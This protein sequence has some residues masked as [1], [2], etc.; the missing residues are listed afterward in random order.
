M[1]SIEGEDVTELTFDPATTLLS[2]V[3]FALG[4]YRLCAHH[5]ATWM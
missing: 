4:H 2:S 5:D 3:R 1:G